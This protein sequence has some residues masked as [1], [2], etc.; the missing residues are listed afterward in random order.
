VE[1]RDDSIG[2]AQMGAGWGVNGLRDRVEA[3]GGSLAV[4]SPPGSGTRVVV[5]IPLSGRVLTNE[6]AGARD[7]RVAM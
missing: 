1:V 6:Q 3:I 7:E 4:E 5:Q 2:G